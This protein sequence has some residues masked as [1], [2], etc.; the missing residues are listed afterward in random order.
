MFSAEK[1]VSQDSGLVVR[2]FGVESLRFRG[3]IAGRELAGVA[4]RRVNGMK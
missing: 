3:L 2:G 1:R 4:Y